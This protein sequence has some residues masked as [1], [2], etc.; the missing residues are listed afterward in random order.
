MVVVTCISQLFFSLLNS[1]K[2]KKRS[3]LL[4]HGTR[5]LSFMKS[6]AT[7]LRTGITCMELGNAY[8][9]EAVSPFVMA[10]RTMCERWRERQEDNSFR[11]TH[12]GIHCRAAHCFMLAAGV[13]ASVFVFVF[14]WQRRFSMQNTFICMKLVSAVW[15][16][17]SGLSSQ[18]QAWKKRIAPLLQPGM[19]VC[20]LSM[21][22]RLS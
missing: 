9:I 4:T 8:S 10:H 16:C 18:Q 20:V 12:I 15:V 22:A 14:V 19:H 3:S 13:P 11:C 1:K 7:L 21:R 5:D 2:K 6:E 17:V